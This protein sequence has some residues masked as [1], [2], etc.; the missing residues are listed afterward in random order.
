MRCARP[1]VVELDDCRDQRRRHQHTLAAVLIAQYEYRYAFTYHTTYGHGLEHIYIRTYI[2]VVIV[3]VRFALRIALRV[4]LRSVQR[5][6]LAQHRVGLLCLRQRLCLQLLACFAAS[7]ARQVQMLFVAR[8]ARQRQHLTLPRLSHR[9]TPARRR[10][11]V[12]AHAVFFWFALALCTCLAVTLTPRFALAVPLSSWHT[13]SHGELRTALSHGD[14]QAFAVALVPRTSSAVTLSSQHQGLLASLRYAGQHIHFGWPLD[15]RQRVGSHVLFS[16][17]AFDR[18][19][20]RLQ[21]EDQPRNTSAIAQ[22]RAEQRAQSGV[23]S[24]QNKRSA[25]Q[26]LR[27]GLTA[28][29]NSIEFLVVGVVAFLNCREGLAVEGHGIF[30]VPFPLEQY[31]ANGHVRGICGKYERLAH[32]RQ[33]L[34]G[35][36][37][38]RLLQFLERML[39]HLIVLAHLHS[40]HCSAQAR[41]ESSVTGD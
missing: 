6:K 9:Q 1:R 5:L 13:L 39:C 40:V 26:E 35:R 10:Q 11:Q 38:N 32:V 8:V 24:S 4:A 28:T 34:P 2:R 23:V 7:R 37:H 15:A 25:K 33:P 22:F 31:S 18:E 41:L 36:L 3:L 30:L 19:D 21:S 20:I 29:H 17:Y 27:V 14:L 12:A 16:G